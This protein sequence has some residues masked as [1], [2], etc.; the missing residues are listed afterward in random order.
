MD[1]ITIRFIFNQLSPAEPKIQ[2]PLIKSETYYRADR[3]QILEYLITK[4]L[5]QNF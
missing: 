1:L 4:D 5:N 2:S 3:N